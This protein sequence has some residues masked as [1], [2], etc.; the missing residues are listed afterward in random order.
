MV[1]NKINGLKFGKEDIFDPIKQIK[2]LESNP[3]LKKKIINNGYKD[4]KKNYSEDFIIKKY[5]NFFNKIVD[6][7]AELQ[8]FY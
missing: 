8:A 1:K 6:W 2:L 4:F 5:L 7:C 3:T